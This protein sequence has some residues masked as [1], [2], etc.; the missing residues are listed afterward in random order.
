[1]SIDLEGMDREIL[2]STTFDEKYGPDIICAETR[3]TDDE[4]V[5]H[6]N[7]QKY[8]LVYLNGVNSIWKKR[9]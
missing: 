3:E 4:I 1:M 7:S 6:M 9:S 2:L 5:V 8:D